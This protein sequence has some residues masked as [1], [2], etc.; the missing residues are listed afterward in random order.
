[1]HFHNTPSEKLYAEQ[2][3]FKPLTTMILEISYLGSVSN[4]F[5]HLVAG[6][7]NDL[8][9]GQVHHTGQ[10]ELHVHSDTAQLLNT[11]YGQTSLRLFPLSYFWIFTST[12]KVSSLVR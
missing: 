4:A 2:N 9:Y 12:L 3:L 6:L 7:L 10:G 5:H 8:L 1:M 11:K